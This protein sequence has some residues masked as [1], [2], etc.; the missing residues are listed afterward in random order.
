MAASFTYKI[1]IAH[2]LVL[3]EGVAWSDATLVPVGEPNSCYSN[4]YQYALENDCFYVEGWATPKNLFPIE[5]AWCVT[6]DGD[7]IDL[8]WEDGTDYFGVPF[9]LIFVTA[10]MATTGY[11]GIL[12]NLYL[13]K[14]LDPDTILLTLRGGISKEFHRVIRT[15]PICG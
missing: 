2:Q 4:A 3:S 6:R 9:D 14:G 11:Y 7:V 15:Q 8:T 5:H 1:P 12:S 13:L 10:V